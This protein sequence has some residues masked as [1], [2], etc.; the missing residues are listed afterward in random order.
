VQHVSLR[1]S[2]AFVVTKGDANDAVE[3]W[4]VPIREELGRVVYV[5]Q[6]VG[7]AREWATGLGGHLLVV[8]VAVLW[9]LSALRDIWRQEAPAG[10]LA[11]EGAAP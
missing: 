6:K 4:N 5:A 10:G 7:Y 1:G 3:R 8:V 9:G 11:E 2:R